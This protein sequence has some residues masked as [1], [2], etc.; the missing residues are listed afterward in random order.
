MLYNGKIILP[1]FELDRKD[2]FSNRTIGLAVENSDL[3]QLY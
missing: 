3:Q 1:K 2:F